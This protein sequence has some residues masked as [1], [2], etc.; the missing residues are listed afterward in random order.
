MTVR[1]R[2][3]LTLLSRLRYFAWRARGWGA[4]TARLR[5]GTRI[6]VRPAPTTDLGTAHDV[7]ALECY[8]PPR[9]LA[10][11]QVLDLGANVG[12]SLLYWVGLYP[13]A[14][15]TA[16]E[17]H[18]VHCAQVRLHLQLNRLEGRVALIEAAAG[19]AAG[20]A[21]L[22]DDENRSSLVGATTG[23]SVPVVDLF[24]ACGGAADLM[25]LD[26]EG[27]EYPILADPRFGRTLRP[28]AVVL[29]WHTV[30]DP[31]SGPGWCERR[32]ADLGYDTVRVWEGNGVGVM[33]A[34]AR[35]SSLSARDPETP[36]ER[37]STP[38]SPLRSALL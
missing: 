25:K 10:V 11:K 35:D 31:E 36:G 26:I 38:P 6:V 28:G 21:V 24:A 32:F 8:R 37:G 23:L 34:F 12:Y 33:W 16:F 2:D 29:E 5:G 13:G 4:L 15:V 14:R 1:L 9:P 18:P 22:T 30:T 17:P 19:T 27:A 20:T 7:L 3:R